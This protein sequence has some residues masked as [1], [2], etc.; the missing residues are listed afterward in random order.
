MKINAEK[1]TVWANFRHKIN[2]AKLEGIEFYEED[3]KIEI[4]QE[5]IEE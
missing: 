4:P 3:K 5:E 2:T 1:L